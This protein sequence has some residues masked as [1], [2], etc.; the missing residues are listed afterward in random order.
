PLRARDPP[1]SGSSARSD[2]SRRASIRPRW[3]SRSP[4]SLRLSRPAQ[5]QL[6]LLFGHLREVAGRHR[7][8]R[9]LLLKLPRLGAD[10]LRSVEHHALRRFGN[11]LEARLLRM[12]GD[13]ARID[14]LLYLREGHCGASR[15][16]FWRDEPRDG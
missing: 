1:P 14:D 11:A 13:A 15:F 5:Q 7:A 9:E 2:S 12:A 16:G 8:R 10:A 4:R 6:P 3:P